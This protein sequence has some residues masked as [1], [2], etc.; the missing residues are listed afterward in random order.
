[1]KPESNEYISKGTPAEEYRYNPFSI[2][3]AAR[4]P[5]TARILK[6]PG[7]V[8]PVPAATNNQ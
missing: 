1:M 6:K 7:S 5:H 2:N 4:E 8:L 3:Q